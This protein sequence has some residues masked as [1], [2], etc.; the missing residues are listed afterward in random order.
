MNSQAS[1]T[2]AALGF[3]NSIIV[4]KNEYNTLFI[5]M[6]GVLI[7]DS[8]TFRRQRGF[9]NKA[10]GQWV[11]ASKFTPRNVKNNPALV[12]DFLMQTGTLTVASVVIAF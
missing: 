8:A 4:T 11:N 3:V 5:E 9:N 10:T 2:A 7:A 12:I 6:D 1:T